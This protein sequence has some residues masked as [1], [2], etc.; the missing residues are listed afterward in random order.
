MNN[1][2]RTEFYSENSSSVRNGLTKKERWDMDCLVKAWIRDDEG[3]IWAVASGV[4]PF[5]ELLW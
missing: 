2:L 4:G 1:L 5:G 3:L